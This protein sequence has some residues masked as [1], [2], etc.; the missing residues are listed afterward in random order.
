MISRSSLA[1]LLA[2]AFLFLCIAGH[3]ERIS[4][5][6]SG[7][8]GAVAA[9]GAGAVAAGIEILERGGNAADGAAATILALA[10]TDYGMF[11]IGGEVPL[12]I[13][14]AEKETVE[15]LSGLGVAPKLASYDYFKKVGGIPGGSLKSAAVPAVIDL[16]VTALRR[17]GTMRF[18]EAVQP[19]LGLMKSGRNWYADLTRTFNRLIEAE[20][21]FPENREKGLEAVSDR[22]YRGDIADE[23]DKWYRENDGLIRKE[24]LANH[25][26]RIEK[27]A[28]IN[29]RGYTVYKCDAWTQGPSL[30]QA[31]K[32]LEG[33]NLKEMGHLSPDYIHTVTEAMKLAFADRDRFYADPLFEKVP[34][35]ALLSDEY[36]LLRRPL[37]DLQ[38][39][40]LKVR[41]GDPHN[42]KPLLSSRENEPAA[43]VKANDT[44]TCVVADRW[45]NV[46]AATPSG[47]GSRAGA[48]GSTGVTHGTRLISLNTWKGHPNVVAPGKRPRI[49]LTPTL[50][51]KE[52][53]PVLAVSVLG[54]DKQDQATLQL[55][56]DFIEFD[57]MPAQAV[58]APRF[59]TNHLTGSFGQ[60]RPSL[61]SLTCYNNI[62]GKVL[63]GLRAKGHRLST[64]GGV[65]GYPVMLYID[66]SEMLHAAGDPRARRHAAALR[67]EP[68]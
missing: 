67:T 15:V 4:W 63:D 23:L 46:I 39:A 60:P 26:T 50:V 52:G 6:G 64:T 65:L 35:K 32:L 14:S 66:K 21:K 3:A 19:A 20:Q 58:T 36:T 56:L 45:G 62:E 17:H 25:V 33:F 9:G 28:S 38:K 5:K 30:L 41:P 54:G 59:A 37:I 18:A 48:G 11:C 47:W 34:M 49:T 27:P 55:L 61:G 8:Y 13:Y 22:F 44:T 57:M 51:L 24:D 2:A 42:M 31:L 12:I 29:Y 68:K 40:S 10:I 43:K 7:K 1:H 16:V 53:K